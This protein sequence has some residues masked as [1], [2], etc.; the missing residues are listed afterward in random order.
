MKCIL[1][2]LLASFFCVAQTATAPSS[3]APNPR[4]KA[5]QIVDEA[6]A[7]SNPEKR[8]LAIVAASL[9]AAEPRTFALLTDATQDSDVLVRIAACETLGSFEDKRTIPLLRT[10]LDD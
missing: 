10:M 5:W 4:E 8:R 3:A 7:S 2:L 9:G 6:K 1:L